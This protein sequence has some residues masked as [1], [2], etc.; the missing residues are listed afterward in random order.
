MSITLYLLAINDFNTA[1]DLYKCVCA[2][3][4][5]CICVCIFCNKQ[6]IINIFASLSPSPTASLSFCQRVIIMFLNIL[7][8]L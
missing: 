4:Y 3:T 1:N 2:Y 5:E 6:V 7:F 8:P